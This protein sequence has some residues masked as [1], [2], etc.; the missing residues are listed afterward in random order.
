MHALRHGNRRGCDVLILPRIYADLHSFSSF[1]AL[2]SRFVAQLNLP[3]TLSSVIISPGSMMTDQPNSDRNPGSVSPTDDQVAL[4]SSGSEGVL[5]RGPDLL[6]NTARTPLATILAWLIAGMMLL[7]VSVAA[8]WVVG[9]IGMQ[10][11]I[12]VDGYTQS[13]RTTQPDV[14]GLLAEQGLALRSEDQ[15]SPAPETRLAPGLMVVVTP[16]PSRPR[17]CRWPAAPG[18]RSGSHC[19]GCAG[20][21]GRTGRFSR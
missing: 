3:T 5:A 13:F 4:T 18:L 8:L 14:A 19:R 15:V 17:G 6:R 1:V 20:A 9:R 7:A 12:T 16:R 21:G 10:V 2:V 11:T